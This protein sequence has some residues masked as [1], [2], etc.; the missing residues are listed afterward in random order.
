MDIVIDHRMNL[1]YLNTK[2]VE[3]DIIVQDIVKKKIPP[4]DLQIF[5]PVPNAM[6]ITYLKNWCELNDF[7][8]TLSE[9]ITSQNEIL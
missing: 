6:F 9:F 1:N 4:I 3:V 7:C 8:S 5:L 2:H